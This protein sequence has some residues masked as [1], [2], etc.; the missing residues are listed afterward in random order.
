VSNLNITG[1]TDKEKAMKNIITITTFLALAAASYCPAQQLQEGVQITVYTDGY[2]L[3]KDRRQ[4]PVEL[5][6]GVNQ[7]RFSQVASSIEADSVHFISLTDPDARVIEQNYEFDLVSA[8][9]LLEKYIDQQ[10]KALTTDGQLF[11]GVLLAFDADQLILQRQQGLMILARDPNLQSVQLATLPQGL[12]TRP[13]LVWQLQTDTPGRHL[14]QISYIARQAKWQVDYNLA[15]NPD[16]TAADLSAWV[17]LTNNSGATYDNAK[18]KLIAGYTQP[19]RRRPLTYGAAYYKTVQSQ[20]PPS[21]DRGKDPSVVFGDLRLYKLPGQYTIADRQIK[22]IKLMSAKSIPVEKIYV[23]DGAKI[24]WSPWSYYSDRSF[25]RDQNT[26]VNVLLSIEN[27]A[28][29]NLGIALPAG[30]I[31]AFKQD[32]DRALE[33]IGEDRI[34]HVAPNE[35]FMIYTGDAFDLVGERKQT[36]FK[37]PARKVIEETFEI[38]LRNHKAQPVTVQVIEKMYRSRQWQISNASQQHKK[39]DS[40]TIRFDLKVP[41]NGQ[42]KVTYMV[43]YTW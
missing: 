13:T 7:V 31:R 32:D 17:T 12:L 15:I 5:Q 43:R 2:A 24:Q 8:D 41:P 28:E 6:A 16:D 27:R 22:Q 19:D 9:K 23:Y 18:I 37:Q 36:D 11:E 30:K 40:R 3:V 34:D 20:L 42:G 1:D 26:K 14:V 25:G 29:K 39:L 38:T 35:R 21:A 33:F 10:I 4:L